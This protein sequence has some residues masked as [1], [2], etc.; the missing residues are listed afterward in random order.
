MILADTFAKRVTH[1]QQGLSLCIPLVGRL[2]EPERGLRLVR[3]DTDP[4]PQH[5][6]K[7][8]LGTNKSMGCG[9]T[10]PSDGLHSVL[11]HATAD[12][13]EQ[14]KHVLRADISLFCCPTV[15]SGRLGEV[16][17]DAVP[18]LVPLRE[19]ERR[20]DVACIRR[21]PQLLQT[22]LV[23]GFLGRVDRGR[24]R[25]RRPLCACAHRSRTENQANRDHPSPDPLHV[26]FP[27]TCRRTPGQRHPTGF[28]E[29]PRGRRAPGPSASR[30]LRRF[31]LAPA[32]QA[33]PLQGV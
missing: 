9:L 26:E 19:V 15:Q 17:A 6:G 25:R 22:P 30:A 8:H 3:R 4:R 20:A 28:P 7:G 27:H 23:H 5:R 12:C 11:R 21:L 24:L 13:I 32:V 1:C 14:A 2:A 18:H 10:E 31:R 33:W 29:R 16:L